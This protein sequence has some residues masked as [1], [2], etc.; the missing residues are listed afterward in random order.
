MDADIIA[1]RFYENNIFHKDK[2]DFSLL[3]H[4]YEGIL[5]NRIIGCHE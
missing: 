2:L 5:V 3:T 4:G 1:F